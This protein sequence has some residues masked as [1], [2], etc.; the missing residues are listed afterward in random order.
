MLELFQKEQATTEVI[1]LQLQTRGLYKAKRQKIVQREET[2]KLLKDEL[3]IEALN[4]TFLQLD[5]VLFYLIF[6]YS[7]SD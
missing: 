3:T 5:T 7:F 2:I 1:I 4:H 6:G